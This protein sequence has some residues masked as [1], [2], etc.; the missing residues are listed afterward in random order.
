MRY[1]L[2]T[3]HLS[4]LQR[5]G[6]RE[7]PILVAKINLH[8]IGD[9]SA[10]IVS[11]QEQ[12]LGAHSLLSQAKNAV[13]LV[14]NYQM[15]T[16]LLESYSELPVLPFDSNSGDMLGRLKPGKI[17]IGKMDLRIAAIALANDIVLAT[18]NH[19]DFSQIP[20]LRLVDWTK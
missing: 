14:R 8:S 15:L 6:G 10:C 16:R 5:P 7:Y 17:R 18:R 20:G 13:E 4:I 9:V 12:A 2:D 1:L 11:F 19:S 3:D